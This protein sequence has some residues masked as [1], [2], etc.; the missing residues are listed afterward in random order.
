MFIHE[1]LKDME[2][3]LKNVDPFHYTRADSADRSPLDDQAQAWSRGWRKPASRVPAAAGSWVSSPPQWA[4]ARGLFLSPPSSA[5]QIL[6][7]YTDWLL[8]PLEGCYL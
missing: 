1:Q 5:L 7:D 8:K 4:G 2:V 3:N 6:S